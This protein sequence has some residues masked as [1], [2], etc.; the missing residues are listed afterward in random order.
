M[1]TNF[2]IAVA[3]TGTFVVMGIWLFRV[4][5][6]RLDSSL[7]AEC[8]EL[9][10]RISELTSELERAREVTQDERARRERYFEKISEF[11]KERSGWQKLYYEQAI[12]HGNA[13]E[14]MM[15]TIEALAN[16]VQA[17]GGKPRIPSVLQAVRSEYVTHHELPAR[18]ATQGKPPETV[19]A[20][21]APPKV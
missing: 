3:C 18:A 14:L 17:L 4:L 13:Q 19:A 2:W 6:R 9:N 1:T 11:E 21:E 12:G 10:R 5:L 20:L 8:A 15:G 16:Q 7:A